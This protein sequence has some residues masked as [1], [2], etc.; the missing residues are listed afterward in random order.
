MRRVKSAPASLSMMVNNKKTSRKIDVT[1]VQ[2]HYPHDASTSDDDNT[3]NEGITNLNRAY[4]LS[5]PNALKG[6]DKMTTACKMAFSSIISENV[7]PVVPIDI[8]FPL[9]AILNILIC[10]E[11]CCTIEN[12]Y[13]YLINVLIKVTFSSIV[14]YIAIHL[15]VL[16]YATHLFEMIGTIHN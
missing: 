1:S 7:N 4:C 3:I 12:I 15:H 13:E 5:K 11:G 10:G 9:D 14:H 6:I 8:Q 16:T 2:T